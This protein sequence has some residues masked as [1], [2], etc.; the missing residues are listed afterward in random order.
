MAATAAAVVA[1]A[2]IVYLAVCDPVK[3]PAPQCLFH[4][5]TG[6]DCPG[7]GSQRAV[8]ALLHGDVSAAWRHNAALFFAIPVIAVYMLSPRKIERWLY[9]PVTLWCLAAAIAA[10]WLLRNLW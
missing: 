7:C 6:W 3:S 4:M 5:L 1:V 9:S 10:W 8:H 2:A